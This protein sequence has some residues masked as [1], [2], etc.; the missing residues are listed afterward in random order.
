MERQ[1]LA[2]RIKHL[3]I[4]SG[5]SQEEL[6]ERAQL[7]LRTIQRIENGE[8]QPRGYSLQRLAKILGTTPADLLIAA[9][10]SAGV[11]VES[12]G[13]LIGS[14][15]DPDESAGAPVGSAEQVGVNPMTA[16]HNNHG[17]TATRG[18]TAVPGTSS[19][20]NTSSGSSSGSSTNSDSSTGSATADNGYLILLNLSGL[21][22]LFGPGLGVIAPFILWLMKKEKI[23]GVKETGKRVINFQLT[24]ALVTGM[25][26]GMVIYQQVFHVQYVQL[27]TGGYIMLWIVIAPRFINIIYVIINTIRAARNLRPRYVPS[28]PFFH[29]AA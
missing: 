7:S 14:S 15:G 22:F 10:E 12:A 13:R 21:A 24:W 28:I 6:S 4:L 29:P 11:P 27:P 17:S 9:A 19:G 20:S 18:V 8:S 2:Q 23:E 3:R 1:T 5:F 26:W 25:Y 16:A